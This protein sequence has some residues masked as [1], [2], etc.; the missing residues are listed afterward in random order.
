MDAFPR[1]FFS[2]IVGAFFRNESGSGRMQKNI[3]CYGD[4]NTWGCIPVSVRE[5]GRPPQR[6]SSQIRWPRLLQKSLGEGYYVVEEG[7]NGR[8]TNLNYHI[9]PDR[10]GKTYLPACL[11]THAPIDLVV[12]ALGGNDL[13]L[14]YGRQPE[15]IRDGMAELIDLIQ[16]TSYGHDLR[17]SPDILLAIQPPPLPVA[18]HMVDENGICLFKDSISRAKKLATLYRHLAEK[19]K[20]HILDLSEAGIP[21]EID[22]LHLDEKGH[23]LVAQAAYKKILEIFRKPA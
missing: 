21:S 3:L 13:K 18:E 17:T 12:L 22:G 10:N 9:P 4:S 16:A 14:Y 1:V 15:D 7:L 5:G 8:T 6:Y 11:Y 19:K 20:C 23:K 2:F